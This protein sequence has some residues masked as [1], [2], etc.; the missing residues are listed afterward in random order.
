MEILSLVEELEDLVKDA[1]AI[2]FSN[3]IV[4]DKDDIGEII[5]K[6]NV[7]IPEEI[8]RAKWI[9]EEKDQI[10]IEAKKEAEEIL[11]TAQDEQSRL[12]DHAKFEENRVIEDARTLADTLIND[13]E[14]TVLAENHCRNLV[15]DAEGTADGIRTGA[16]HYADD[17]LSELEHK[18]KGFLE[19]VYHN[20]TELTKFVKNDNE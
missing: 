10:L 20:R 11:R 15:K 18:L 17:M 12:L 2:P 13:N 7:A 9:K 16:Y 5:R 14:I 8:R 19:T 3:R 4:L 6:I 1:S